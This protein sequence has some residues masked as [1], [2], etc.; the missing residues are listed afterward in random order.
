LTKY[1]FT[2][3]PV[4]QQKEK[5]GKALPGPRDDFQMISFSGEQGRVKPVYLVGGFR[6]GT[7]MND[8]YKLHQEGKTFLWELIEPI[9]TLRPE[10]RSSFGCVISG[11]DSFYLFG[12][13]GD[14]NIKYN[15]L[16]EFK[17]NQWNCL[18][19]GNP[20]S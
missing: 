9:Q 18:S 16:W 1:A 5:N 19:K 7:K 2:A 20:F 6:N 15:D 10:P 11:E 3:I 17:A 12:G 8:I 13:S 4:A 14:N